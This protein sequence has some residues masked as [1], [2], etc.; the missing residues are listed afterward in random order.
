MATVTIGPRMNENQLMVQAHRHL[1]QRITR[2]L[3]LDPCIFE[4]IAYALCDS[5]HRPAEIFSVVR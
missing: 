2:V 4:G 1:V 3:Q 5:R